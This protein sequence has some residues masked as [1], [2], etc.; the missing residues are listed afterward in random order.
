MTQQTDRAAA[1]ET[2]ADE[3]W[4][5]RLHGSTTADAI[6]EAAQDMADEGNPT[7]PGER[8]KAARIVD[9]WMAEE[10]AETDA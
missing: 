2:L 1:I 10:E 9:A 5:L 6:R 4:P 3:A 7:T 8:E